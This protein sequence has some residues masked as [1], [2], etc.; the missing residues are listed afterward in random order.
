MKKL[1]TI[2]MALAFVVIFSGTVFAATSYG[3]MTFGTTPET[4]TYG[5]SHNVYMDYNGTSTDYALG[6]KH[7][8]GNR[9]YYTTNNTSNLYYKEDDD[10]KGD[11]ALNNSLPAPT[12]ETVANMTAL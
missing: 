11:T 8:S 6:V 12:D 5:L 7:K 4:M 3:I 10:Y 9:E 1:I 2:T